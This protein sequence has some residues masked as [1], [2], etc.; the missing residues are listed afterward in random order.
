MKFANSDNYFHEFRE[1][2]YKGVQSNYVFVDTETISIKENKMETLYFKLG[3]VIFWNRDKND[4]IKKSYWYNPSKFWDDLEN[5]FDTKNRQ[6]TFFAHNSYFDFKILNGFRELFKRDWYLDSHYIKGTT[7]MMCFKKRISQ[8]VIYTLKIWDTL[9]YVKEPLKSLGDSVG[10]KKLD[11]DFEATNDS[12]LEIY[13]KR[14]VEIIYEFIRR[15]LNFLVVNQLSKLKATAGSLSLSAFRN[16]FYNSDDFKIY[17]HNWKEAIKLERESYKGGI[18]DNFRIGKFENVYKTDIN[19]EYPFCMRNY[20]VPTKLIFNGSEAR[21]SQNQLWKIY[22]IAI[23]NNHG[24]IMKCLIRID[25][26]N[27]FILKKYEKSMFWYGEDTVAIA[28]PEIDFVLEYGEILHIY[29]LN[30]YEMYNV[31]K[32]FV[33]FFYDLKV[34]Y[35]KIKD[36]VNVK[37]TK[38][39]LNTQ[40]G[41]WGQKT[42]DYEQVKS[43]SSFYRENQDIL[44]LMFKRKQKLILNEDIVYLGTIINKAE[45]YIIDKRIFALKQTERNSKDTFVAIPSFITSYARM[46]LV[47]Y[48]KLAGK[49]N[50]YY[51]DTDSLFLNE[52]GYNNLI[53]NNCINEFELGKLKNEGLVK[54]EFFA[55]KYYDYVDMKDIG[56][57][58]NFLKNRKC[59]GVKKGSTLL[60]EDDT[61]AKYEVQL[62]QK[63]KQDL[64]EGALSEQKIIDSVK[65]MNKIYDKGKVD[66]SGY[67]I[68]YHVKEIKVLENI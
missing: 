6:L 20:N 4:L 30:V 49:Q 40:Y 8:N 9:N 17:I 13:C 51:C 68:P 67:V 60:F 54:A 18:T 46:L 41:K 61:V 63:F 31:F 33:D 66:K 35:Q 7:F 12:E 57:F 62:W 27:A 22:N 15:L 11:I 52:K 39:Y 43:D 36:K 32:D 65:K 59:K 38:L 53:V 23:K 3:C 29:S 14:D 28:Q 1:G 37:I 55:P 26:D 64:K 10:L 25:K 56:I 44:M 5:R 16:R 45:I 58:E 34:K 24:C 19:S 47:K 42:I 2:T 50:V 48:L 21:F